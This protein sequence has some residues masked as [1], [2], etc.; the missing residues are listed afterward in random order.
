[1]QRRLLQEAVVRWTLTAAA[2]T[3]ILIVVLIFMK[4]QPPQERAFRQVARQNKAA[5]AGH[6]QFYHF[7]EKS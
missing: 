4:N 3:S 6:K 5:T 7:A 2:S 1:M